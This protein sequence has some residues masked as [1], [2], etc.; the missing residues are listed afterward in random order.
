[1]KQSIQKMT[2]VYVS[3]VILGFWFSNLGHTAIDPKDII[4]VWLFDEPSGATIKDS[5]GNGL[6]GEALGKFKRKPGKFGGGLEFP[7]V[8]GQNHI[9]IPDPVNAVDALTKS[10]AVSM[11]VKIKTRGTNQR[12]FSYEGGGF[13]N[14]VF[15]V[16]HGAGDVGRIVYTVGGACCNWADA[17]AAH[18]LTD[19]KWHHVVG[20]FSSKDN[21][22]LTFFD[23][24]IGQ[25]QCFGN[26]GDCK[27]EAD[28]VPA[29][30]P[31]VIGSR[32]A[33]TGNL[34]GMVDDVALF[35]R[36]LSK[37]EI[38][39]LKD[40]GLEMTLAISSKGKLAT[41]WGKVKDIAY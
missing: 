26:P 8:D 38:M 4:G 40:K 34:D 22:L 27:K 23:G 14:I 9:E 33:G 10:Y 1:M 28:A 36:T 19:N 5:S 15:E 41:V 11:Y 24:K 21:V 12:L 6:D 25:K 18:K 30:T 3:L 20:I 37:V 7:G 29:D 32:P 31:L 2:L 13:R 16:N 39:E 17:E 35:T